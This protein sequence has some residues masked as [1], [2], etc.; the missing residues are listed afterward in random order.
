MSARA[1]GKPV[2]L[3]L[4]VSHLDIVFRGKA[5]RKVAIMVCLKCKREEKL[6]D[7][8]EAIDRKEGLDRLLRFEAGHRR[9]A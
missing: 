8:W 1:A 3:G 7:Y 4:N 2:V 9:C 6:C 5:E